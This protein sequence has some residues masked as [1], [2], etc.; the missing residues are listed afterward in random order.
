[1]CIYAK[2]EY[3][4]LFPRTF[5]QISSKITQSIRK[6]V[7]VSS[8]EGQRLQFRRDNRSILTLFNKILQEQ[9]SPSLTNYMYYLVQNKIGKLCEMK[10]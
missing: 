9:L 3:L 5:G 10:N 7:Q 6:R 8:N 1:M 2:R 4:Y